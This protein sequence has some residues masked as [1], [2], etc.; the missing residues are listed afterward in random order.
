MTTLLLLLSSL[1][2]CH[3]ISSTSKLT[4]RVNVKRTLK[5]NTQRKNDQP[6]SN[7]RSGRAAVIGKVNKPRR[8][9]DGTAGRKRESAKK[10]KCEL[11]TER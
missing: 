6:T 7:K 5:H 10:N 4:K 9:T 1:S 11:L 2:V 8:T 3:V